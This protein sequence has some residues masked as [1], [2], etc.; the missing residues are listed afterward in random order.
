M[1]FFVYASCNLHIVC[2]PMLVLDIFFVLDMVYCN[3]VAG[4]DKQIKLKT[5]LADLRQLKSRLL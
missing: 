4:K 5:R 1:H 3:F 2:N